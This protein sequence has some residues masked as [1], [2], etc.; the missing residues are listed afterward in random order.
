MAKDGI[1]V[2][3]P[4]SVQGERHKGFLTT[5]SGELQLTWTNY[6]LTKVAD[7]EAQI[8]AGNI[9]GFDLGYVMLMAEQRRDPVF[10][11]M[12]GMI[13][14]HTGLK[15]ETVCDLMDRGWTFNVATD[16]KSFSGPEAQLH[17]K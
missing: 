12:T 10:D 2:E 8:K 17:V 1:E 5:S 9:I 11:T 15:K 6:N 14:G 3:I 16:G 4:V 13:S 7:L